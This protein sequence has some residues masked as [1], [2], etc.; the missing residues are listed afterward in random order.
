MLACALR[1]LAPRRA[2][3][4]LADAAVH[5]HSGP[6]QQWAQRGWQL[7]HG[8]RVATGAGGEEAA[9]AMNKARRMAGPLG[10]AAGLF[11]SIVGV[12]GGVIIV[13]SIVAHCRTIPQR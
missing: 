6:G 3:E 8:H 7:Q 12:G 4:Q 5:T 13:P 11:G 2:A 1:R 10:I 9:A